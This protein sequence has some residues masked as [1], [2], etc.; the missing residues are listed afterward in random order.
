MTDRELMELT[1][2]RAGRH[3]VGA[4]LLGVVIPGL[5]YALGRVSGHLWLSA[6]EGV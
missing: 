6:D 2:A 3:G 5:V 4:W 1:I